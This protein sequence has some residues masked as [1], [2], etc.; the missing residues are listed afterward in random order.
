[1]IDICQSCG[2][3]LYSNSETCKYCGR[4][5]PLYKT[6]VIDNPNFILAIQNSMMTANE[7]RIMFGLPEIK[8]E[9]SNEKD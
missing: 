3:V 7:A 2:A 9:T 6:D 8:E 1:M 5:N 4:I